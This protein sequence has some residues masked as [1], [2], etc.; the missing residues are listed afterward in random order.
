MFTGKVGAELSRLLQR[1]GFSLALLF[2][3]ASCA[4]G[5]S[6]STPAAMP[7]I[8]SNPPAGPTTTLTALPT[9]PAAATPAVLL[10]TA[11]PLPIPPTI[12]A[13]AAT[14]AATLASSPLP[15][16]KTLNFDQFKHGAD[17]II[18]AYMHDNHVAACSLAVVYSDVQTGKLL[19]PIVSYGTLSKTSLAPV[20]ANT[21]YEIGSLSKLLTAD[22]LAVFIRDGL[23]KLDDPLQKYMP[24]SV[25]V[26]AFGTRQITLRDLATHTSGLPR[27]GGDLPQFRTVNGV[28]T[29]GY[30][31]AGEI[32]QA[33]SA[34]TLTRLPGSQWEYS[35]FAFSLLGLAEEKAG[36]APYENLVL[37]KVGGPLGLRDMRIVLTT[38]EKARLAQGYG[39]NGTPAPPV[40]SSG[41]AL[42]AGALRATIQDLALYL[43]ANI[44]PGST[45][46]ASVLELTLQ[47][48]AIG[49]K[50]GNAA[51]L[52]WNIASIG[53]PREQFAK[54]GSTA[55]YNAY[56]TF[57]RLSRAG[58]AIVCDGKQLNDI[59]VPLLSALF[60][61]FEVAVDDH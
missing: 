40:A 7:A 47:R 50:P 24:P 56:I 41:G 33:L 11:A 38:A 31:T 13:P 43:R 18:T 22:L 17:G 26:P 42:A 48:Q 19:A 60:L 21:E 14:A 32:E 23:M 6:Q 36:G 57:S 59:A 55:G 1:L 45:S 30:A 15:V 37:S 58:Y 3:L 52:G 46:L 16:P 53:T 8:T 5:T 44:D 29:W 10:V 4:S 20:D 39:D 51:G 27:L 2:A 25:H 12:T 28:L 34:Y 9:L 49:A 54:D 61:D 35:N